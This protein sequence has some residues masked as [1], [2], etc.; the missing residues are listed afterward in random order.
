RFSNLDTVPFD[1]WPAAN[2][3][4]L[5]WADRAPLVLVGFGLTF[6]LEE[7]ATT[8]KLV[9]GPSSPVI[10]NRYTP[11][12]GLNE[13]ATQ[14]RRVMPDAQIRVEKDQLIVA[15]RQEDH[16]KILRLLTGQTVKTNQPTKQNR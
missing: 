5:P 6:E 7:R 1:L 4:P 14:L 2:L 12:G 8:A 11:R 15:A 3:P 13:L 10:E 16:D 9:P